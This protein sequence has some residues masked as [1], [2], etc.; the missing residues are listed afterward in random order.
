MLTNLARTIADQSEVSSKFF[1]HICNACLSSKTSLVTHIK[2][3]HLAASL[4]TCDQCGA[5][6]KWYMQLHRHRRR[7]HGNSGDHHGNGSDYH[8]DDYLPQTEPQWWQFHCWALKLCCSV[9]FFC[10]LQLSVI[11]PLIL[12]TTVSVSQRVS[13]SSVAFCLMHSDVDSLGEAD[14][15]VDMNWRSSVACWLM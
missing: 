15:T 4:F 2:G 9:F 7:F 3:S 14:D 12:L 1:C 8:G 5:S 6:F 11:S 13:N 10:W